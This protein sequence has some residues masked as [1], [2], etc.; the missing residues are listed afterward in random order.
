MIEHIRLSSV[1]LL[2]LIPARV[3]IINNKKTLVSEVNPKLDT[4]QKSPKDRNR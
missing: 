3:T 2:G 1:D 4:L